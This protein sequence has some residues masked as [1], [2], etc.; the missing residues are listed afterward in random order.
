VCSSDLEIEALSLMDQRPKAILLTDDSAARLA[1]EQ[2]KVQAQG[3]IGI[4]IRSVRKGYRSE[5]EALDLL[6]NLP[7]RS[8]LYIRPSLLAEIIHDLYELISENPGLSAYGLSK[9]KG[10]SIGRT[11]SSI[12]W[13]EK[14]GLIKVEHAVEG[15]RVRLVATPKPWQEFFTKE[16]LEEMSKPEFMDEVDTILE[17]HWKE[18]DHPH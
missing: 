12:L 17:K 6:R 13:L 15:G 4:L 2:R 18:A 7:A 1:A 14:K 8:T 10:W 16:E 5:K 11:H 9:L 3:T